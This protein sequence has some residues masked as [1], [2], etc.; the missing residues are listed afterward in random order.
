MN[1]RHLF[2]TLILIST[3]A[4]AGLT[5][6]YHQLKNNGT[7]H[8]PIGTICEEVA[9]L[10]YI[11]KY[12]APEFRVITGI[13]YSDKERTL[14]ELDLVVFDTAS[15]QAVLIAEVKCWSSPKSGLKKA[16][17]QRQRFITNVRSSKALVFRWLKD[18]KETFTK[19]QFNKTDRFIAIAQQG[20][21]RAG[22]DV[23][24]DYTLPELMQLREDI[25][26]CQNSGECVKPK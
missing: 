18:P 19:T 16:R 9:Q 10:R 7:N 22:F 26:A 5:E 8:S 15:N 23:E 4:F 14:G 21:R 3:Q 1:Y 6:D 17:E 12:P 11:E 20:S 2:F 24:L 13:T 25:M